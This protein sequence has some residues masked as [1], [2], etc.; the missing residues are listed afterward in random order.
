MLG[1]VPELRRD[2]ASDKMALLE[3]GPTK[4]SGV[5]NRFDS[6]PRAKDGLVQMKTGPSKRFQGVPTPETAKN[7]RKPG[8]MEKLKIR[9]SRPTFWNP[10]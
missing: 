6:T 3:V 7:H 9:F 8:K 5:K 10:G 2:A 4:F 1:P